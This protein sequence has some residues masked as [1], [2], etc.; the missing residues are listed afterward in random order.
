M[1]ARPTS[2]LRVLALLSLFSSFALCL[3]STENRVNDQSPQLV[4]WR[5]GPKERGTIKLLWNCLTTIIACTWTILHLNVPHPDHST[6]TKV[7]RKAKWMA[8]TILFP[9]FIFAKAVTELQMAIDDLYVMKKKEK[10]MGDGWSV[11]FGKG[12]RLV[13][14]FFHGFVQQEQTEENEEAN[15]VQLPPGMETV[16]PVD[17]QRQVKGSQRFQSQRIWTLT[18]SYF[19]NMGGLSY[20]YGM[21]EWYT[22]CT[23]VTAHALVN[24]C[25]HSEHNPLPRIRLSKEDILDKSKADWFAKSIAVIQIFWQVTSVTTRLVRRLPIS[26][27][28]I[29]TVAFAVL[30][31][32]TYVANWSK[33]K[34]IE[35]SVELP[36]YPGS[37]KHR[38]GN[39]YGISFFRQ[40]I[41]PSVVNPSVGHIWNDMVR[42]ESPDTRIPILSAVVVISTGVFGGL[43]CLAWRTTFPTMTEKV[44]WLVA[45]ILSATIP[46][47]S[48]TVSAIG[49]HSISRVGREIS[50]VLSKTYGAGRI[51]Q[52]RGKATNKRRLS[53]RYGIVYA[54]REKPP[55]EDDMR[56]LHEILLRLNT[57]IQPFING[58]RPLKSQQMRFHYVWNEAIDYYS[59]MRQNHPSLSLKGQLYV[60]DDIVAMRQNGTGIFNVGIQQ[61]DWEL[62]VRIFTRPQ[63]LAKADQDLAE[64]IDQVNTACIWAT[65]ASGILYAITRLIILALAF[66]ALRKQDIRVY[67][68]VW[69]RN[70]PS[71]G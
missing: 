5:D 26:Q 44:V 13:H 56:K 52:R 48:L 70:F 62:I 34:D 35:L 39:Y 55:K 43:H 36:G 8:M 60:E 11:E 19:A 16:Q 47:V 18:H 46:L 54:T 23:P 7:L 65:L 31:T 69:T 68:E 59:T 33:P 53:H 15:A 66:A 41:A 14:K 50:T 27:L 1:S 37:E 2:A 71:V 4:G 57:Q 63:P 28:E 58:T 30:A 6:K 51:Q 29:C 21:D 45:S 12:E 22:T 24:C 20:Q 67:L 49:S 9:E 38:E 42:L 17:G 64:K 32:A 25:I 10:A 40:L 3:N 61:S